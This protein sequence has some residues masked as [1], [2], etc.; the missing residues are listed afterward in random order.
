MRKLIF[1]G[2]LSVACWAADP[3]VVQN[4]NSTPC[5]TTNGS[6]TSI[7]QTGTCTLPRNV[8]AGNVIIALIGARPNTTNTISSVATTRTGGYSQIVSSY[9][10]TSNSF[11]AEI[12][13]GVV[14]STGAE[15]AKVTYAASIYYGHLFLAEVSGT[16][17]CAQDGTA[18]GAFAGSGAN[19]APGTITTTR[20]NSILFN[21]AF[22]GASAADMALTATY[23]QIGLNNGGATYREA[24]AQFKVVSAGGYNPVITG[25]SSGWGDVIMALQPASGGGTVQ[26]RHKVTQQ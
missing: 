19:K 25:T 2:L 4:N 1:L 9:T 21:V 12:W 22:N 13:C 6:Y 20:P 16:N 26:V 18:V 23:T 24:G 7:P 8:T 5:E 11:G 17:G 10:A 15:A 3:V 14:T